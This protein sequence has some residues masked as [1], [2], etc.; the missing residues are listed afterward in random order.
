MA[1]TVKQIEAL[2][3]GKAEI[4]FSDGDGLYLH[5][6]PKGTKIWKVRYF[7]ALVAFSVYFSFNHCAQ[8]FLGCLEGHLL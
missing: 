8:P 7:L 4:R 3:P 6:T 5:V 1:L 2:K